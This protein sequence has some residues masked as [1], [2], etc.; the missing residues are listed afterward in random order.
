MNPSFHS[1]HRLE[2][3]RTLDQPDRDGNDIFTLQLF[4]REKGS[5]QHYLGVHVEPDVLNAIQGDQ[6]V[7]LHIVT[8]GMNGLATSLVIGKPTY[9]V[10]GV[11][12]R[13]GTKVSSVPRVYQVVKGFGIA[14][15]IGGMLAGVSVLSAGTLAWLGVALLLASSHVLRSVCTLPTEPFWGYGPESSAHA[16]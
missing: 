1:L 9:I 12:L 3:V 2:A 11:V 15:C 14:L 10:L 5:P 8:L 13:D 16:G 6:V 7:G 4:Y